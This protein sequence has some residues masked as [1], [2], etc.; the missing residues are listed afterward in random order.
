MRNIFSENEERPELH[1][2]FEEQA[3]QQRGSLPIAP[4]CVPHLPAT[5][6]AGQKLIAPGSAYKANPITGR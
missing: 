3:R 6:P 2:A 5:A 1:P 4:A